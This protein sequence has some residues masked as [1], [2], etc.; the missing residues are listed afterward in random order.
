VSPGSHFHVST[1][2][3]LFSVSENTRS[4]GE[5]AL[6]DR[7]G[8]SRHIPDRRSIQY[9]G[10]FNTFKPFNG[11]TG[12]PWPARSSARPELVEGFAPFKG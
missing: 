2:F 10:P 9:C 8:Q 7:Q 4:T 5:S 1:F 3:G 6:E 12:S 11:S